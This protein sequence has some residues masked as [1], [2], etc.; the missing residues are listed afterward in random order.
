MDKIKKTFMDNNNEYILCAAIKRLMPKTCSPYH[1]G[2]NDICDIELGYRHH[3]IFQRFNGEVSKNSK[4]QGF[5][6]SVKY[7][8]ILFYIFFE[9]HRTRYC[10]FSH[11][12]K[13][14]RTQPYYSFSFF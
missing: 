11:S 10:S 8:K 14:G 5:Y 7:R 9:V 12:L 4:D 1:K 13:F 6:S 2:K 3:D